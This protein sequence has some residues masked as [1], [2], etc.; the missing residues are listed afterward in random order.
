MVTGSS[1]RGLNFSRR[2]RSHFHSAETSGHSFKAVVWK[3]LELE[4]QE[5]S[6]EGSA[7]RDVRLVNEC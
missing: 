3:E 4:K 5:E 7:W 6:E 2:R 1:V